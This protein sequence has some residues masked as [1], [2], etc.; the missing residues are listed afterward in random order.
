MKAFFF[1]L[2]FLTN[3][4]FVNSHADCQRGNTAKRIEYDLSAPDKVY[5][6]PPALYEISG[7]TETDA[8]TIACI[9]DEHG[10]IFFYDL[11]KKQVVKQFVFGAEGDYEDIARVE[12]T[13]WVMRS[14]EFLIEIKDFSSASFKSASYLTG[15]PGRD[16]EGLCYDRKNNRLLIVPKEISDDNPENKDKRFIY[17]FDLGSKK[18][19]KGAALRLDIKMIERF[20]LENKIKVP[21]KGKK[22]EEKKPDIKLKISAI[23]I[24]PISG[25][26]YVLSGTERLL[27]VFDMNGNIEYLERLDKDLFPQPEGITFMK[28]GDMFISN[29]GRHAEATL[30]RFN[31]NLSLLPDKEP[32]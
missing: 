20:A 15:I 27:L 22:G 9:Q 26:L 1:G 6:L 3:I 28:N 32:L 16:I 4:F 5:V 18:L 30:I 25:R 8:S 17:G 19:I 31:Y 7:M 12:K 13:L 24:H 21:V 29:E 11:N 23:S 2:V 14:D 10:I